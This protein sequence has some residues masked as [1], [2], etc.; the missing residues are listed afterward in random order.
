MPYQISDDIVKEQR[1]KEIQEKLKNYEIA[2]KKWNTVQ[3]LKL[4]NQSKKNIKD[5]KKIEKEKKYF[6]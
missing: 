6:L 4:L 5:K 3:N 1:K 2:Q